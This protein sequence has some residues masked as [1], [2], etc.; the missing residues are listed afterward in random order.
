MVLE[1]K[2]Q[3]HGAV[4]NDVAWLLEWVYEDCFAWGL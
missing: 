1:W 2:E 3:L 4:I